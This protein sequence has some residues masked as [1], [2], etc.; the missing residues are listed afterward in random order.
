MTRLFPI[1]VQNHP[2]RRILS[3]LPLLLILHCL[4]AQTPESPLVASFTEYQEH[5]A[6]T[7]FRLKWQSLGPV[8]NSARAE[9][10]QVD[11]TRPGTMYVAFG[12]GNL[13][14]T[15]DNGLSWRPLFENQPA[16]GI[17]DIAL[18]PSNPNIIY[19][20][21]GESLRKNR[22]F[23]MPGTG[24]YR[25]DDGGEHWRYLGLPDSW[26]IGEI[27]VHPRDPDIAY[28][29]VLGRFWSRNPNRGIYRTMDGGQTWEHVLYV[30]DQTGGNDIVIAPSNPDIL[31]ASTWEFDP[32]KPLAASVFGPESGVYRSADGGQTWTRL[33][34]GLPTGARTG[35][36][37]L[38]VSHADPDKVY[39]LIDN[40]NKYD[41][42][43]TAEVYR[44][45]DGGRSWTRTH[46]Q[47]L[48]IFPGIGW[49]FADIYVNP[50]DDEEIFALGVRLAHSRDGGRNFD[51]IG[52]RVT[53]LQPSPAQTLH[54][55]HC[56]LWINPQNPD[57]LALGNDGGLYVSYDRGQNWLHHNNIPAGEFY[58]VEVDQQAPYLIYAGAQDDA[59]V[60]GP[61]REWDDQFRDVWRYLW[62]DAWSGGDGCITQVDPTDPNTVYFSL[63]EG[64]LLRKDVR[65]DT[66]IL[67]APKSQPQ[68]PRDLTYHFITPYFISPHQPQTLYH[69]GNYVHKSTNRGDDWSLISPDLAVSA[70]STKR[71][72]AAGALA[73]SPFRPG[74]LY[75]GTDRGAFW[76][77]QND[78]K[79]WQERSSGLPNYYIRSICPSR[80]RESRVYLAMSGLNYDHLDAHLFVSEDDGQTWTSLRA[81]LP[82]E[83]VNV[84]LEDPKYED[85]LYAGA[86]RGVY[87]SLDRGR[88][89][90]L[91]GAGMPNVSV[92]DLEIQRREKHL[93]AATHGRG[94]YKLDL[95]PLYRSFLEGYPLTKNFLFAIPAV[96]T[97]GERDTHGDVDEQTVQNVPFTFWLAEAGPVRLEVRDEGG[98]L[99]WSKTLAGE[100]GFNQFWWDLVTHRRESDLPYFIHYKLY[101]PA[102][103]YTVRLQHGSETLEEPWMVQPH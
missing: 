8:L 45:L 69:A 35:R 68:R 4:P 3:T 26:H 85:I 15:T 6:Q 102:G 17:G 96:N 41:R 77:S 76:V 36:I 72:I 16:Q 86:Y 59:T 101:L 92:A 37:G 93:I 89:W 70:D 64:Y 2:M 62:I 100:K 18:A 75:A 5:R 79:S 82:N 20:G 80:F 33:T 94:I 44:S 71:S 39:A 1:F 67:I 38:A 84:I 34:N 27:T 40:C 11:H 87:I 98:E 66:S 48:M 28:V 103:N 10:V 73:E 51:L 57:H 53:H 54:L 58:D 30:N 23:T 50:Q 25:S 46:E 29:A 9:A 60:Y 63:Q 55:D 19:L 83:T 32:D 13:W 43:R 65:A 95:D 61:A 31:Y 12:S 49:Y 81:N 90:S 21:T 88:S 99:M 97:P 78:G 22:N 14:K 7:P 74:L 56:E 91:L 52:G 42:N 47:D 24:V